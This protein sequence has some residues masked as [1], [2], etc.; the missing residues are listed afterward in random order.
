MPDCNRFI[1]FL[2]K[3]REKVSELNFKL[4][5]I[6][7]VFDKGSNSII[8]FES[9]DKMEVPYVASLSVSYCRDLITIPLQDYQEVQVRNKMIQCYRTKRRIWGKERT[10]V[11]YISEKLREGQI[12]GLQQIITKRNQELQLL[13]EKLGSSKCKLKTREAIIT[14]VQAIVKGEYSEVINF[15]V[16][17]RTEGG[18]DL[19]WGICEEEYRRLTEEV[20][21]KKILVTCR[22]GWSEAEI[23]EAYSGQN[24]VERVF[25]HFKNPYHHAIRP[26]YHWT[27]QKIRVHA[28]ICMMGLLLSQLLWKKAC[29]LGYSMSLEE[30]LDKLTEVRKAEIFTITGLKGKPQREEIFEEMEPGL[31]KLHND[32]AENMI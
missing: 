25:K 17:E 5:E 6:T 18:Y 26:Q 29:K 7:V 11:I 9:M 20:F 15:Q 16:N 4:E 19:I 8:N 12:S 14:S 13:K 24:H 21:G 2:T 28:F 1:S 31:L 10:V 23:I 27:D 22:A 3:L 30:L 32:L